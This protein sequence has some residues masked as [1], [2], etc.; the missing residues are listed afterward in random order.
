M[1]SKNGSQ[2][3]IALTVIGCSL[4]LLAAL[5]FALSGY[6]WGTHRRTLNIQFEDATGIKLHSPV[7]YAGAIAGRVVEIRYMGPAERAPARERN[8]AVRVTVRLDDQ[9]PPL[10][11]N[12]TAGLGSE[13]ILGEKFV[14]LSAGNPDALPLADGAVIHGRSLSGIET[15]TESVQTTAATANDLLLKFNADYPALMGDVTRLLTNADNF[16]SDG[17]GLVKDAQGAIADVRTTLQRLDGTVAGIGPQ[18]SNLLAE[19]TVA[20]T[21]LQRMIENTRG[22]TVDIHQF[23]TN[24]FLAN[25]DQ[26]MRNLTGVLARV[27]LATEYAK[28]LA[29][30][31]AEKPSR[32]IWQVRP[33]KLPSEESIRQNPPAPSSP[34][35]K[36]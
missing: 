13:T 4:V 31:L 2:Y 1:K 9:V 33:N 14:A 17:R 6:R 11:S 34:K 3:L 16:L 32:L 15:L 18:A 21:N 35:A 28:I 23:L 29:A 25:L 24:Q 36:K 22:I 5:T 7:R 12:I 20:T 19:A 8:Y 27:E 10:P 30:R 26:N